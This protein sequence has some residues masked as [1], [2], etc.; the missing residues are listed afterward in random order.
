ML[1]T[2]ELKR[3]SELE[4]KLGRYLTAPEAQVLAQKR[5]SKHARLTGQEL[6]AVK[7]IFPGM[8]LQFNL[9]E[10]PRNGV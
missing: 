4:R 8:Q 6:R 2:T 9:E 7:R 3:R 10:R 1:S 5:S